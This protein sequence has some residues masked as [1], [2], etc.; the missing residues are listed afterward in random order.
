MATQV[1]AIINHS[2]ILSVREHNTQ[3]QFSP[4]TLGIFTLL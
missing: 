3:T 2:L 4:K 1:S